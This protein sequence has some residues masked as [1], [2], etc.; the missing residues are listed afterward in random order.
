[1]DMTCFRRAR[2]IL[3]ALCICGVILVKYDFGSYIYYNLPEMEFGWRYRA[4]RNGV[5]TAVSPDFPVNC[6]KLWAGDENEVKRVNQTM[7]SWKNALSDEDILREVKNCYWLRYSFS[8]NLYISDLE[9]DFPLA[10]SLVVYDSPQ[11]VL[12][13]LRLLYRPQNAY[14]IHYDSKS[15]HKEFYES[16]ARCFSNIVI[17]SELEDVIWGHYSVLGAQMKCMRALLDL[18]E[19][20]TAGYFSQN[21]V[22]WKYLLNLCGK[23]LPLVTNRMIIMHLKKLKG[24]LC[25]EVTKHY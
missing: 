17:P 11:Q 8:N 4:W 2:L 9:K 23:E 16:V 3:L 13:L 15:P 5:V 20:P 25:A 12:R 6:S 19:Q 18:S 7:S 14:C 24:C 22:K 21:R 10:F 1:M